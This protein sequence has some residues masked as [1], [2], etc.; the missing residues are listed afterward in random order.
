MKIWIEDTQTPSHR[1]IKL[2]CEEHS[3][4]HFLGDLSDEEL[5]TFLLDVKPDIDVQKNIKL[6]KYF[7]Y[8]HIFVIY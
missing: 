4:F 5:K 8:L 6:L 7:G 3:N 1:N 2:N